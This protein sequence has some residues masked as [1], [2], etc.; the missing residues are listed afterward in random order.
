M[1]Y[2]IGL[3]SKFRG[4][5]GCVMLKKQLDPAGRL[6]RQPFLLICLLVPALTAVRADGPTPVAPRPS[7]IPPRSSFSRKAFGRSWRRGARAA[8]GRPSRKGDC[9]SMHARPFSP[10]ASTGPAVVPGN[11]KESLLVDAI[12]Y[13]ETYQM[14]PKSKLPAEEI[15]TLTEWVKRGAPWGVETPRLR[16]GPPA[17][18]SRRNRTNF[19]GKSSPGRALT[20]VLPAD[21]ACDAPRRDDRGRPGWARN[22]IDRFILAALAE[23]GLT[24]APEADRQ[25]LIR[26]L[27]FDLTGLA[28]HARRGR[29][30]SGR[31]ARRTLTSGSSTGSWPARTTASGGR[32]TGSTWS[33]TPRPPDMS[34][35]T[36]SSTRFATATT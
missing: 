33:A 26:R 20:L 23:R 36:I 10:A 17:S 31:S 27:S 8:T 19:P 24:P 28:P 32:G 16:A 5:V 7:L 30:V 35:T 15:A 2:D 29:R 25:T 3:E 14:P 13:G 12:N 22:P 9:G 11:P 6:R 18:K 1:Y 34:S 4:E 21:P